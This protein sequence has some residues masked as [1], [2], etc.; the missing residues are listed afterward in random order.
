MLDEKGITAISSEATE[1][2]SMEPF[3]LLRVQNPKQMRYDYDI[4]DYVDSGDPTLT[5]YGG[6]FS[7]DIS[8]TSPNVVAE[9]LQVLSTGDETYPWTVGEPVPPAPDYASCAKDSACPMSKFTD[10]SPTA[11]YHDGVHYVLDEGIMQGVS[12]DSFAP[13]STTTRAMIVTMLWR[14]EGEPEAQ[15]AGFADTEDGSWYADAVNWAADK[16][17]VK[18]YDAK[19]FGPKDPV[20]REQIAAILYRYAQYKG[21]DVSVGE[22]TE[23][24]A[25]NDVSTLS[26]W[27]YPAMQWAVGAQII[28][29]KGD[30]STLAPRDNATRAQVA[31]MLMRFA[32]AMETE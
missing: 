27:A 24:T 30:K 32:E 28:Q 10:A 18:G 31:T 11:W 12:E 23:L 4:D 2:G 22:S 14:M 6:F 9:G 8:L 21:A 19:T 13:D 26:Q 5:V 7:D 20:T 1:D 3:R 25:F 17:I 29:G 16:G 15:P